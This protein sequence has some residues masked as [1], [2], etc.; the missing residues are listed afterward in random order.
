M[1]AV[2]ASMSINRTATAGGM[3]IQSTDKPAEVFV[4]KMSG[5]GNVQV[6]HANEEIAK[7]PVGKTEVIKWK[8]PDGREIEGLL[9]YPAGTAN[10]NRAS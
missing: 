8:S 6:S 5:G 3:V 1:E 4:H 7:I 9:T 10:A 2:V